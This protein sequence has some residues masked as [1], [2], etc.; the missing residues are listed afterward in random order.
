MDMLNNFFN[1][2]GFSFSTLL[3]KLL[4][5]HYV[6]SFEKSVFTSVKL[7]GIFLKKLEYVSVGHGC[8]R[9]QACH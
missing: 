7:T 2:C 3:L 4:L 6:W 8:P 9:F 5:F 1:F